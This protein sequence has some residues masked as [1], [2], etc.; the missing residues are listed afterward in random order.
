[1]G[2]KLDTGGGCGRGTLSRQSE[3]A[4]GGWVQHHNQVSDVAIV[5]SHVLLLHRELD[6]ILLDARLLRNSFE[7]TKSS[8][9]VQLIGLLVMDKKLSRIFHACSPPLLEPI[10]EGGGLLP[11]TRNFSANSR[12]HT[13]TPSSP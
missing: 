6:A 10:K 13:L 3:R 5:E 7:P 12:T 4:G 11:R 2:G 9:A 8:G 1:M